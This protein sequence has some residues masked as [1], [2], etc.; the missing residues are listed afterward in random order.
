MY[1]PKL[2][3][4]LVITVF[5]IGTSTSFTLGPGPVVDC[6]K[7]KLKDGTASPK[8]M[9]KKDKHYKEPTYSPQGVCQTGSELKC[10]IDPPQGNPEFLKD[11][12]CTS[13]L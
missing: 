4:A 13:P 5:L 8:L 1:F 6:R 7:R 9:C 11:E 10:C 2:L 3:E 12:N